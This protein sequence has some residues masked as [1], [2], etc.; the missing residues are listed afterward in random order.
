M[1]HDTKQ[2]RICQSRNET[3][4]S[5]VRIHDYDTKQIHGFAKPIHVLTNLFYN[6]CILIIKTFWHKLCQ[7]DTHK[8][9]HK[10]YA[11]I[12]ARNSFWL[13]FKYWSSLTRMM[14]CFG[15]ITR[16]GGLNLSPSCLDQDS[17][18]PHWQRAGLNSWENLD[19][20]KKFVLTVEKSQSRWR[21]LD[22]VSTPPSSLKSLDQDQ[23]ICW[24]MTFLA[25]LDSLSRSRSRVS[26]F[27][28]ISR[29][30]FLN[31]WRFLM[32]KYLKKSR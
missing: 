17:C 16:P 24:H 21:N 9:E 25:N 1:I 26:Q 22:F 7:F 2:I 23:E 6:S 19:N 4:L 15:I 27:N 31:L 30:R 28:P 5:G 11:L 8:F 32:V 3:N 12:Y 10:I 13:N 20:F 18:S 29:S 14:F